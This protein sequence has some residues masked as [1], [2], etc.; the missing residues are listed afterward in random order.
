MAFGSQLS[1][2]AVASGDRDVLQG[3]NAFWERA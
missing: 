3:D 2:K 1:A